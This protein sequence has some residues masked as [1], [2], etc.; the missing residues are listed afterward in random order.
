MIDFVLKL[1]LI[2]AFT[3][4]F[5][6]DYK[7]RMVYWYLYPLVGILAFVLQV[8]NNGLSMSLINMIINLVFVCLILSIAYVYCRLRLKRD[9]LNEVFGL[10]DMLFFVCICASFSIVL[11]IVLFVFSLLFSLLLHIFLSNKNQTTVPLAGYMSVFFGI[12]YS[13][14]FVFDSRFLYFL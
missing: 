9:F 7:D 12:V 10:G 14:S 5:L 11:F 13:I 6:Q 4:I 8:R 2:G 1:L 3:I